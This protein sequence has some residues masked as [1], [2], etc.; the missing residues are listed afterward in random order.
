VQ[1]RL[2]LLVVAAFLVASCSGTDARQNL[3]QP[4][5]SKGVSSSAI[6]VSTTSP[7]AHVQ[8]VTNPFCP[9]VAPFNVP[10]VIV[11]QPVGT[12]TVDV[13][14]IRLRFF[15]TSGLAMP[16]VTL[17]APV[18]TTQF[19]SALNQARSGFTFPVT[20]GIGCGTGQEGTV[21]IVVETRD[22]LGRTG[23]GNTTVAVR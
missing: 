22:A 8:R 19:G 1:H 16:Q 4:T 17:P 14:A 9:S 12:I 10:L 20:L 15:D 11:V 13:T 18:P 2:S 23:S 5:V 7:M 6:S 3:T 21:Q